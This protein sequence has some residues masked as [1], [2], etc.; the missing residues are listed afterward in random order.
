MFI[1]LTDHLRCPAGHEEQYLV[2]I[3]DVMDG[4]EVV[5]GSLG[6]PVCHRRFPVERGVAVFG[7]APDQESQPSRLEPDAQAAL[8]G[9]GGPGGFVAL[10]G[11]AAWHADQIAAHLPGIALVM[12][13][14]PP[15]TPQVA[16][17]SRLVSPRMPLKT[18][19]MRAVLLGPDFGSDAAWVAEAARVVLPGNRVVGEG[20]PPD[21]PLLEL[22]A[23]ADDCWVA[24]RGR[25]SS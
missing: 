19:S 5:A 12:V 20:P 13:N 17:G 9:L 11:G 15:G 1:E 23:S 7:R 14:P 8:A 22:S 4:R 16:L 2:L 6:C 3:P 18:A 10:V 25:S 24:T 21:D